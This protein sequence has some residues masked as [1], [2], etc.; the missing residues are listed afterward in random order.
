MQCAHG[1]LDS[2]PSRAKLALALILLLTLVPLAGATCGVQCLAATPH[3]PT[4]VTSQQHCVVA[5]ACCHSSGPA[6]CSRTQAPE[7]VAMLL[8]TGTN[9]PS[10]PPASGV[11]ASGLLP[12]DPRTRAAQTIDSSPPGQPSTASLIPLRI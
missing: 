7:A 9:A 3:H 2:V 1:T 12:Q 10:D 8:S 11:I 6:V 5:S 4:H